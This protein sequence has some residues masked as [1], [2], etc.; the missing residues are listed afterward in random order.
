MYKKVIVLILPFLIL[1]ALI[2]LPAYADE[3]LEAKEGAFAPPS[4]Q[5]GVLAD[6]P[7]PNAGEQS[8]FMAGS[9]A[10][11][12]VAVESNGTIDPST[13]N[14]TTA[15]KAEVLAEIKE[16]VQWW[17]ARNTGARLSFIF[18]DHI[19]SPLS[20]G[21]E[22]IT[23]PYSHQQYWVA[24]AMNGLG[25]PSVPNYMTAVRDF[26]QSLRVNYGTDWAFTVFVVDSS[27]DSDNLFS[28]GYFAYAYLGGPFMVMTSEVN[29]YG[30]GNVDA[31][32]AHETGHIFYALDQYYGAHQP[33]NA[34]MGYFWVE[35]QNSQYGNC[36]SNVNS[37][38]R[39]QVYPYTIGAIDPYGAG[40]LGWVDNDLDNIPDVVDP[41]AV[42]TKTVSINGSTVVISGTVE[43][44]P[45]PA[46]FLR[47]LTINKVVKFQY[48]TAKVDWTDVG[49]CLDSQCDKYIEDF[50]ATVA[51]Q[52]DDEFLAI[53][54]VDNFGNERIFNIIGTYVQKIYLPLILK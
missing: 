37:I 41:T 40:H 26:N 25:F 42:M 15:E 13:E 8:I 50:T 17:T 18:E 48:A 27:N 45:T 54:M 22:P 11:G 28:D 24:D 46:L 6:T 52:S 38:M 32:A 2:A 31:V 29:G 10:V 30:T 34:H 21:V 51:F 53:R 44:I 3:P 4:P 7:A 9:V 20:T 5:I 47:S 14:W 36:A 12:L 19:T 43:I 49:V 35:N 1:L 16:G 33:C 23:R 39:G